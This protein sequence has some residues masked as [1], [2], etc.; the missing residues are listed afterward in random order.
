MACASAGKLALDT[1]AQ[2]LD[3]G[4]GGTC[5]QRLGCSGHRVGQGITLHRLAHR[6]HGG[7]PGAQTGLDTDSAAPDRCF[8]RGLVE[9]HLAT[10][11]QRA[12]QRCRQ[13]AA[14]ALGQ[15]LHVVM[16]E[17][18]CVL[19]AGFQYAGAVGHAVAGHHLLQRGVGRGGWR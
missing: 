3:L 12:E 13:H 5:G 19:V 10:T 1:R 15:R 4:T 17:A 11:G 9:R 14:I 16:Q 2:R 6:Q 7:T 18:L 8:E